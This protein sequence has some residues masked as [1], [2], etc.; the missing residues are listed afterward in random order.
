MT[1]NGTFIINGTERVIV[2]QL[3]R[4]PGA[5]FHSE[6]KTLYV[7]QIIPYR[8]SWVEFEFDVKNLLYVR[9]DRKRKFPAT[10]FLRALGLQSTEEII[11]TFYT[12][13][14][15]YLKP[16]VFW[17]VNESLVG[18]AR[19]RGH[20]DQ[21]LRHRHPQGQ[22]D[23]ELRDRRPAEGGRRGRA[24]RRRRARGRVRGA[25]RGGPVHGRGA[26]AGQ[27]GAGGA[28]VLDPAGEGHRAG[29]HL[30]PGA[31]RDR[32]DRVADA[33]EGHHPEPRAG[34][35]RDLP[36]PA[37][38]RPAHRGQLAVAVRE[39]VLQPAEVRLLAGRPP[40]AEH[41]ARAEHA[42]RREDPAPAGLLRGHQVPAEA[43]A[44]P[45]GGGRHRPPGQPARP[46]GRRTPREPVP[47]RAG[48]D[49]ARDQGE[50]VGLPGNGDRHAAR[51]DQREAGHG[52][53][54]RVLRVVAA[55]AVHGPD[56][57]AVRGHA[58]APPLGPRA[59]RVVARARRVRGARR[60]PDALRP[61][62]PDRDAGRPEHRPDLVAVVLLADQRVR[63]HRVALPQGQGR[64]RGRLRADPERRPGRGSRRARSSRSRRPRR[65]TRRPRRR[66]RS[67]PSGSR[68]RSTSRRGKRT[69]TSSPRRTSSSTRTCASSRS[70]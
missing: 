45:R 7:A 43:A 67:R 21:G 26:R 70:G 1:E 29:G 58:Q 47:H 66:R 52:R 3:H 36:A 53:D 57:P 32:L 24:D 38:R 49:G 22:E 31:R 34:A 56:Q 51:P 17:T 25:G 19:R 16:N 18:P 61:H 40:E 13:D 44:Q 39:H 64:P 41:Q 9:I 8:G 48:P 11:R 28:P 68:T 27:R 42:A 6:D 35:R 33:A 23:H 2:S 4:S 15:L 62:L 5:F 65:R 69:S 14:R 20:R 10:V 54:S 63:L 59:R 55:V 30:L 60:A 12:V 50:D 46:L 37:A